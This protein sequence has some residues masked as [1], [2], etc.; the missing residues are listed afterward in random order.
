MAN[1]EDVI[2]GLDCHRLGFCFACPYND[3]VI[4]TVNCKPNL[5][6]DALEVLNHDKETIESLQHTINELNKAIV[7]K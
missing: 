7:E 1:R 5:V 2:K 3:D 4:S 6:R